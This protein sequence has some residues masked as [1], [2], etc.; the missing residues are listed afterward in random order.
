[1]SLY[2]H[3]SRSFLLGTDP[4]KGEGVLILIMSIASRDTP[5]DLTQEPVRD[6]TDLLRKRWIWPELPILFV[7]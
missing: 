5:R 1:M 2:P 3:P 7:E 4:W 6:K